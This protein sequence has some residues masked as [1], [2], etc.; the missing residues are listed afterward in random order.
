[1]KHKSAKGAPSVRLLR[2][3]ESLRHTLSDMLSR[4]ALGLAEL[5]GH[6]ITVSEVRVSPDLRH[7]TAFVMPLGGSDR[8]TMMAIL[9]RVAPAFQSALGKSVQTKYTPR[10]T[11]RLD[12]SFDE[13][14]R[15]ERLLSQ[16][17]V[18]ADLDKD[19]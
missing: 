8:D 11:F 18:K 9:N 15:I 17:R 6:S 4:N 7:A 13:A 19:S 16:P 3:G 12:E 10:L 5:E 1:M 2:V 14:G